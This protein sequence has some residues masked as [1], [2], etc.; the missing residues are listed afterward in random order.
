MI[1]LLL[2]DDEAIIREGLR[3][4]FDWNALGFRIVGE[5]EDGER[6]LELTDTLHPDAIIT[7]IRM[8][9]IDGLQLLDILRGRGSDIPVVIISGHDDFQFAQEAVELDAYAYILKPIDADKLKL[10]LRNMREEIERREAGERRAAELRDLSRELLL[11]KL[12]SRKSAELPEGRALFGDGEALHVA[13]AALSL[14]GAEGGSRQVDSR[15]FGKYAELFMERL[16]AWVAGSLFRGGDPQQAGRGAELLR[17]S[18]E[19]MAL[20]VWDDRADVGERLEAVLRETL[21]GLADEEGPLREWVPVAGLGGTRRGLSGLYESWKEAEQA[22]DYRIVHPELR[23]V[24]HQEAAAAELPFAL[25]GEAAAVLEALSAHDGPALATALGRSRNALASRG[26]DGRVQFQLLFSMLFMDALRLC[27]THGISVE[28]VFADPA[29]TFKG[30]LEAQGLERKFHALETLLGTLME[31]L[32]VRAGSRLDLLL[33]K[34]KDYIDA[35]FH[36]KNLS[37][38]DAAAAANM[39]GNYFSGKFKEIYGENYIEYL[40]RVRVEK[41]KALLADTDLLIYEAGEAVGYENQTY[42]S[43]VF[44]RLT[45]HSPSEYRDLFGKNRKPC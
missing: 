4:L 1:D 13:A 26:E 38:E 11:F 41:A 35:N 12:I 5:A 29:E 45:G 17:Y 24:R 10:I 22:L 34:A 9:F 31:H 28:E 32:S 14:A 2:V 23:F 25:K 20:C 7:D 16:R 6:A 8:P 42:F 33:R 43:T 39:S 15:T 21:T 27:E 3:D 18:A 19:R 30:V 37:L 36:R 44:K 40:T